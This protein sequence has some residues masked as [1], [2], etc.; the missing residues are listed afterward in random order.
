TSSVGPSVE[1][2]WPT[3]AFSATQTSSAA[4]SR[5]HGRSP[6]S[7]DD[8]RTRPRRSAATP[9]THGLD[10]RREPGER[11]RTGDRDER[12]QQRRRDRLAGR[13]ERQGLGGDLVVVDPQDGRVL[14]G[15]R[16]LLGLRARPLH[17]FGGGV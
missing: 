8:R 3:L 5:T 17:L 11:R 1:T 4:M 15:V 2:L 7:A 9:T 10:D 13:S 16:D 14:R 12:Q 6:A